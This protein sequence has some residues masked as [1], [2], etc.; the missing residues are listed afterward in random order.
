MRAW[1]RRSYPI[2]VVLYLVGVVVQFFLAGAAMFAIVSDTAGGSATVNEDA[3]ETALRSHFLLGTVLDLAPLLL[4]AVA[5][6]GGLGGRTVRLTTGLLAL[7]WIQT[8]FS[9]I[10]PP[11]VRALHVVLGL[12]LLAVT[13]FAARDAVRAA[14]EEP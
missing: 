2:L 5:A 14:R 11:G 8:T 9:A 4:I 13:A 3:I 1:F 12:L 6:I 7:V 10:G